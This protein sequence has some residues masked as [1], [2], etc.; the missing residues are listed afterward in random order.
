VDASPAPHWEGRDSSTDLATGVT[1][2]QVPTNRYLYGGTTGS[3]TG[4]PT[5]FRYFGGTD[6]AGAAGNT[7]AFDN[8]VIHP[9]VPCAWDCG[10][11]QDGQVNVVDFLALLG[12]WGQ[13]GV[14]CRNRARSV[15]TPPPR[16]PAT[17]PAP[18]EPVGHRSSARRGRVPRATVGRTTHVRLLWALQ[19]PSRQ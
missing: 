1:A 19:R 10:D 13:A 18:P 8:L 15:G 4:P 16:P 7:L 12:Q 5:G 6:V 17:S 11:V 9:G 3:A 14:P 2:S